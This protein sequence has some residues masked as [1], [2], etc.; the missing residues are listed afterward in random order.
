MIPMIAPGKNTHYDKFLQVAIVTLLEEKIVRNGKW[1][2]DKQREA[3][4]II[5]S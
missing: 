5:V 4:S 1:T 3:E 2:E